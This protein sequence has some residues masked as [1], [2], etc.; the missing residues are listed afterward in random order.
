MSG[1]LRVGVIGTG[2]IA[3]IVHLPL[4][5]EMQG[6]R[7]QA[8][9]D[10]D[11]NKAA[12]IAGRLGIPSVYEQTEEI[13]E[14]DQVDAVVIC[15]P[16][17]LH[18]EH[19]IAALE[20]GKDVIVERPLA[21]DPEGAEAMIRAAESADRLLM[22]AYNNR[23]RPDT[24]GVKS[25]V[26]S[27]ELGRIYTVH[28]TWFNR[29]SHLRRKTWRHRR[30]TGGGAF[31]DLGVQVLDLCLWML[32]YPRAERVTA[33]LNPGEAMEVEDAAAVLI[34]LEGGAALSVQV[35]WNLV[36]EHD[37]HHV[38]LLGTAGTA[39]TYPLKVMKEAEHGMLNVTPQVAPGREN[40]YT[41]SYRSELR[42]FVTAAR[43]ATSSPLP[44]EQVDV[45]RIVQAV[46]ESADRGTEVPV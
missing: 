30:E 7:V 22:V 15:S 1:A 38:R 28:G 45:M 26:A 17:H 25:F 18:Q 42:H 29:K 19:A 13:L 43:G 11:E 32:D 4:L 3:Q 39:Q 9:C 16:S 41:A 37:R 21:L 12:A 2:A 46:Y 44:R 40:A 10:L 6:V 35:T 5:K 31:M 23:F 14:D 8:V 20:A 33:N 24:R 27:G 34:G 36:A